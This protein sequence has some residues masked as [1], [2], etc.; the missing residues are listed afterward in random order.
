MKKTDH[1]TS[2]DHLVEAE[3]P[4]GDF[5]IQILKW[6]F[7]RKRNMFFLQTFFFYSNKWEFIKKFCPIWNIVSA[8]VNLLSPSMD[9]PTMSRTSFKR[10]E[11][12]KSQEPN[13]SPTPNSHLPQPK[14]PDSGIG[15]ITYFPMKL[16]CVS[17]PAYHYSCQP[18]QRKVAAP[19]QWSP[20]PP[21]PPG[22]QRRG[23]GD[24]F[25]PA[26]AIVGWR[27]PVE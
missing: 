22:D 6:W 7:K 10:H 12:P 9:D 16:T 23:E 14:L 5:L 3:W 17:L 21:W 11:R 15:E 4:F 26:G 2:F 1:S 18:V 25:P 27:G 19:S 8:C 13:K 24:W 20:R